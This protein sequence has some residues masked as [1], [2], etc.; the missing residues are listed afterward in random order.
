MPQPG[1]QGWGPTPAPPVA[2]IP[3]STDAACV[4]TEDPPAHPSPRPQPP[5]VGCKHE[6]LVGS[7]PLC[8]LYLPTLPTQHGVG[9]SLRSAHARLLYGHCK[10]QP[11]FLPELN[12][13][14]LPG[15]FP[16][17]GS[18]LLFLDS[19]LLFKYE[20]RARVQLGS[21]LRVPAGTGA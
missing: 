7:L 13:S 8:D 17:S 3:S 21:A 15:G 1:G 14:R 4:S 6:V 10:L 19:R 9:L 20:A 11:G 18:F 16:I 2:S 12:T 5:A